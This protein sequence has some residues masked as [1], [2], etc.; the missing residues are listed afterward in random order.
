VS[1]PCRRILR[2]ENWSQRK[3]KNSLLHSYERSQTVCLR[4]SLGF[5]E[6]S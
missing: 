3:N 1:D 4:R 2:M 6:R 5:M